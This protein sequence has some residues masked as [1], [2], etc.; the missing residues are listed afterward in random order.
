MSAAELLGLVAGRLRLTQVATFP[1][2]HEGRVLEA[3]RRI[4][5]EIDEHHQRS[6]GLRAPAFSETQQLEVDSKT[7][8]L[9]RHLAYA[10][11]WTLCTPDRPEMWLAYTAGP[12][13]VAVRTN[14]NHMGAIPVNEEVLQVSRMRY[15]ADGGETPYSP[16][17]AAAVL[18]K[19]MAFAFE[20]EIRV[21]AFMP[22]E[23]R[24][25][26]DTLKAPRF[27]YRGAPSNFIQEVVLHPQA[28][29]GWVTALMEVLQMVAPDVHVSRSN[30]YSYP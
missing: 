7:G 18:N 5:R 3:T 27:I 13:A 8:M 25:V 15:Y 20:Q 29:S 2:S 10:S 24:V 30:L 16:F 6:T 22:P 11:C 28:D 21:I 26:G 12:E 1:D 19:R 23:A 9:N 4:Q 14:T 17:G